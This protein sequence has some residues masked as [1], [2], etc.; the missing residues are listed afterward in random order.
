MAKTYNTLGTVAPGDVLRANSGTAAYNGVITNINNFRVPPMCRVYR[1]T[2]LTPYTA[3]SAIT[4]DAES[5]DTDGMHDAVTNT[6]RITANTAG[7]Y[8][9]TGSVRVDT[10]GSFTSRNIF[11]KVNGTTF[12]WQALGPAAGTN[13][14]SPVAFSYLLAVNDYVE[15]FVANGGTG[16]FAIADSVE[17]NITATWL[18]QLS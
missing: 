2:T 1:A 14:S 7:V 18:G 4:W 11:A 13:D 6:S 5:F 16:T 9:F 3:G 15:L 12:V 10:T 17:A 8:S